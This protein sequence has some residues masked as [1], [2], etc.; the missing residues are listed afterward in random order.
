MKIRRETLRFMLEAARSCH[1]R[2]FSGVLRAREGAIAEILLLPGTVWSE[3]GA[4][5]NLRMLGIDPSVC[6]SVHSHP[7]GSSAPSPED[8]RFFD[9]FGS[10]HIIIAHPYT[11]GSW[12]AYNHRGEEISL[13]VIE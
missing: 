10:I 3:R 1:P 6:G 4:A 5:M 9:K 13:E 7:T 8:L 2:E 12:K 11:E